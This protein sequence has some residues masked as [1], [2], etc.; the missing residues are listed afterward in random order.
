MNRVAEFVI[1]VFKGKVLDEKRRQKVI[2]SQIVSIAIVRFDFSGIFSFS[3]HLF[4][5]WNFTG[6]RVHPLKAKLCPLFT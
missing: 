4:E 6:G 5:A 3:I 2:L 1:V